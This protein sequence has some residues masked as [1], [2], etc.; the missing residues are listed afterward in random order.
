MTLLRSGA[1]WNERV[2]PI[3]VSSRGRPLTSL[4][5]GGSDPVHQSERREL[6]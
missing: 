2:L 5:L 4:I 3:A 1:D 6:F